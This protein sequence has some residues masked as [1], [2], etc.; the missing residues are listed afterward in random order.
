MVVY[1]EQFITSL[2]FRGLAHARLTDASFTLSL[3]LM[4][5]VV[6]CIPLSSITEV[7]F[8][9]DLL[10]SEITVSYYNREGLFK[11]LSFS[12]RNAKRWQDAFQH[13]GIRITAAA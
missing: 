8:Y 6:V 1:E 3:V 7:H 9:R 10:G 11:G 2:L 5:W 4:R 13:V 12:P